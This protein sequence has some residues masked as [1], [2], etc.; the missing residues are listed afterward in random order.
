MKIDIDTQFLQETFLHLVNTPSP[1]GDTSRGIDVCREILCEWDDLQIV[2]TRKGALVATWP[3][4]NDHAPRAVTAHIDILG[5]VVREIKSNG[6]LRLTQLGNYPWTAVAI[7]G[8]TIQTQD[9]GSY[10]GSIMISNA[11]HQNG[12]QIAPPCPRA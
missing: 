6:R 10:R 1:V 11:S 8:V 4:Q 5:A 9:N 7:E 3:G 12:P 2:E